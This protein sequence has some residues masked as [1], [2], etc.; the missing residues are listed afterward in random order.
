MEKMKRIHLKKGN[1]IHL[2]RKKDRSAPEEC[3][4]LSWVGEGSSAVCY[5]AVYE[6]KIGKLKEFYPV[7]DFS[8]S[9]RRT[10]VLKRTTTKQL[11]PENESMA[12]Q[13]REMCKDF[14]RAYEILEEAKCSHEKNEVL[15]NYI[16][17]YHLL[18][19][20][21][22]EKTET[23]SVYVWTPDDKKG[24]SFQ[25]YLNKVR[26][27]PQK[28][29][30]HKLYNIIGTMI[31]LT[32]CVRA[33]HHAGL[34]HLDIKPSNFLV[35][36][37]SMF[38]INTAN[39]SLFDINT[40]YP[41]GCSYRRTSGTEGFCA[42]EVF[43]GAA[44]DHSDIYSIGAVLFYAI[45]ISKE[46]PDGLYRDAYYSQIEQLVNDSE[47]LNAK[48]AN[49]NVFLHAVL[50]K[51]LKSCLATR[52]ESRY[53]C[54]EE[55]MDDL[56]QA[57]MILLPDI[58]D[59]SLAHTHK[60]LV[61]TDL[62]EER[63]NSTIAI[64]RLLYENSF[65]N[66]VPRESSN[67]NILVIG[68]GTYAQKF[69]DISLQ[70]GQVPN[71]TL[72]ITAVTNHPDY[73]KDVYLQFRPA[74]HE[75]VNINGSLDGC[76]EEI[77]ANLDFVKVP[78][79]DAV[80]SK[81]N[82][83][84]NRKIIEDII[85]AKD[86]DKA[87]QYVFI[88]LGDDKLNHEIAKVCV[89]AEDCLEKKCS[90][91]FVVQSV[92][93]KKY[94]KGNP[95]Y[96]NENLST[97]AN[98]PELKEV[99][100]IAFNT[101]LSWADSLVLDIR[102]MR[103]EFRERYNYESS[104]SFAL[105][106]GYKLQ[107]LGILEKNLDQ[108]AEQFSNLLKDKKQ[109]QTMVAYEHRRWV[110]E[111]LTDGWAAPKNLESFC[112]KGMVKDKI[113]KLHPCIVRSGNEMPLSTSEYMENNYAKWDEMEAESS[114]D[115][116][117]KM[118]VNLHKYFKEQAQKF[119]EEQPLL[120][121]DMSV[122]RQKIAEED[123]SVLT[124]YNRFLFCLKNILNGSQSYSRQ[125][126]YY[127]TA[128]CDVLS[129]HSEDVLK[130]EIK[131][132]LSHIRR[133]FFP[134]I[135]SNLYC[136]YKSYDEILV[137]KIPFIL[138]YRPQQ[139]VAMAFNEGNMNDEIFQNVAS[140]IVINPARIH[141]LYYFDGKVEVDDF[142]G[143]IDSVIQFFDSRNLHA[144]IYFT[145]ALAHT[146]KEREKKLRLE[147][148]RLMAEKKL[149]SYR[150][151]FCENEDT[152]TEILLQ[153]MDS[154]KIDLFD[155]SVRLFNSS[156]HNDSFMKQIR[157]KYPYFEFV[158]WEKK[159]VNCIK[160]EYLKY[161][162]DKSYI[163]I[164]DMFALRKAADSKFHMPEFS[165]D[166]KILWG[167]YTNQYKKGE[168]VGKFERRVESW[169]RLCSALGEYAKGHDQIAEIPLLPKE[170]G[171]KENQ[172]FYFFP[173]SGYRTADYLVQKLGEYGVISP[174]KS[175][176]SV[177]TSDTCRVDISTKRNIR[178]ELDRIFIQENVLADARF[179]HVERIL[180]NI[181]N[182]V[183][184]YFD[185]LDVT[186]FELPSYEESKI[187]QEELKILEELEKNHFIVQL[188]HREEQNGDG[189]Q[190]YV[191]FRFTSQR[192]KKLFTTAGEILEVYTYYE[193][194]K[195]G[196]FDDIVSGFEFE[197]EYGGVKNEI[198]CILTKGFRS[199][200][201]E[202]KGRAWMED[203]FYYKLSS[204]AE[205]FGIGCKK[206][207]IANTYQDGKKKP[208]L[209]NTTQKSR[210]EQ[211]GIIT[212]SNLDD[213]CNIGETLK[214]IMEGGYREEMTS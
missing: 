101:H 34:L 177:Y 191:S 91:N 83:A 159:F 71:Y 158:P 27:H 49:R 153:A 39:I 89:D 31:T 175:K 69:I 135:E 43:N 44:N 207:M 36:Y 57:Q 197:W 29:S 11:V 12:E 17:A 208:K 144:Q 67:I 52:P 28:L 194:L 147:F 189:R 148:D 127:E 24:E 16:P 152:A 59:S 203:N 30:F 156:M 112:R 155:G 211:M 9:K 53:T 209:A 55:L 157:E 146:V 138:T 13:F 162:E 51:I 210:G 70:I 14:T 214:K 35:T 122:I 7:E 68:A 61:L 133:A 23:A 143:K 205:Q 86:E 60:K 125:Y 90:V 136:D 99:E 150:I 6:G 66:W 111:K 47:L 199:L 195:T 140:A 48:E 161:M 126:D 22:D 8:D 108:V 178:K 15:N 64:Q 58:A 98:W 50:V 62:E 186:D 75:F 174:D 81:E 165:D 154:K 32:D 202:C 141:Y 184:I 77:Y 179:L 74:I 40:L 192:M 183:L 145:V 37:N 115:D 21:P 65:L 73:D 54:C 190:V 160:C 124:A 103:R 134:V 116:L 129:A 110:V 206:V 76:G 1:I 163:R 137:R 72:N 26:K 118:S 213:I 204:I 45:V 130:T 201:V 188:E 10:F 85:V 187:I 172:F 95:V 123:A 113:R 139:S 168:K 38:E 3:K 18:Y 212:V 41:I 79:K 33:L 200:I 82:P 88:A 46:I 63:S 94:R 167:I 84:E 169:N 92:E 97:T 42:P 109:F 104:L 198:D 2:S 96:V 114:L 105:S 180:E 176:V 56:K 142:A 149:N 87:Y 93:K 128:F 121:G 19:G 80:L 170:E 4:I 78:G 185:K 182:R 106:I 5:S 166:Y 107:S 102:K 20:C 171:A 151:L 164:N 100:K 193:A 25:D 132:R 120:D 119:Q 173:I 181:Y 117:D 131:R 196:Y